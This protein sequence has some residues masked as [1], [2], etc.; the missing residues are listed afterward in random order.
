MDNAS[1]VVEGFCAPH[2]SYELFYCLQSAV[3]A[4]QRVVL[5]YGNS[6]LYGVWRRF[7]DRATIEWERRLRAVTHRE[8]GEEDRRG[9]GS[10]VRSDRR[11]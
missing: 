9:E 4:H 2:G 5:T 11:G 10:P 7:E 3:A 1:L 8:E 6:W